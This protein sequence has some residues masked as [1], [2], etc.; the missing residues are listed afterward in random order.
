M[1]L[2]YYFFKL[3]GG[4]LSLLYNVDSYL[5]I[6]TLLGYLM[7]PFSKCK[8]KVIQFRYNLNDHD[9]TISTV[10]F[11]FSS[12]LR[13]N[14]NE[15]KQLVYGVNER[16]IQDVW[17]IYEQ[18]FK[19]KPKVGDSIE[20]HYTVPYERKN[21]HYHLTHTPYIVSYVYPSNVHF[22]PYDLESLRTYDTKQQYKNGILFAKCND[23]DVTDNVIRLA[24]PFGNFYSDL[25]SRYGVQ[26]PRNLIV[27]DDE[28][29]DL[30]ITDNNAD[31]FRFESNSLIRI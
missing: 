28:K 16:N 26:I 22:P 21:P 7:I 8:K 27:G 23:T 30:V 4:L 3:S 5:S 25:P 12:P 11:R 24:G 1:S 2:E 19:E 18:K 6:S 10:Y 15:H 29:E 9:M 20:V 17:N 31:E 13:K 14:K